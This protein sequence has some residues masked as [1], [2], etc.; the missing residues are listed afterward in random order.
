MLVFFPTTNGFNSNEASSTSRQLQ[1]LQRSERTGLL[2]HNHSQGGQHRLGFW[3]F[4]KDD[5]YLVEMSTTAC[6]LCHLPSHW[7]YARF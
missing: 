1:S 5:H 2:L 6:I 7:P 3:T 4:V